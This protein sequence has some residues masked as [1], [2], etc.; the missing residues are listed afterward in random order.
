MKRFFFCSKEDTSKIFHSNSSFQSILKKR[1]PPQQKIGISQKFVLRKRLFGQRS[2]HV[3]QALLFGLHGHN[4]Y[5]V[6]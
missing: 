1:Q 5:V 4:V 2:E 3:L 6:G